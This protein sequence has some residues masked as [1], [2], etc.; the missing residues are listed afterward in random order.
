MRDARIVIRD[1]TI[2]AQFAGYASPFVLE[3]LAVTLDS[4]LDVAMN[5]LTLRIVNIAGWKG[6][7]FAYWKQLPCPDPPRDFAA[8]VPRDVIK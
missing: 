4:G 7:P 3:M 6:L 8:V 5:A 1:L 2:A